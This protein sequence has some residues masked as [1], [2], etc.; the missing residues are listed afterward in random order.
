M[1]VALFELLQLLE[2]SVPC[3]LK[4]AVPGETD[5]IELLDLYFRKETLPPDR[6]HS[7]YPVPQAAVFGPVGWYEAIAISLAVGH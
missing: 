5:A 4:A 6:A 7:A 2:A 1:P 3:M